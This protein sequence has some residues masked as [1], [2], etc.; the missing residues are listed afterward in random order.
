MYLWL[1]CYHNYSIDAIKLYYKMGL[2]IC[3]AQTRPVRGDI[4]KN[5]M[6]LG[7]NQGDAVKVSPFDVSRVAGYRWPKEYPIPTSFHL[8]TL[9]SDGKVSTNES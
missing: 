7:G 2:I 8:P 9:T 3:A 4:D 6:V 5:L 1:E